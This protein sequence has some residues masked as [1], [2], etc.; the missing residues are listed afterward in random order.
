MVKNS[1]HPS[2]YFPLNIWR[3]SIRQNFPPGQ[4]FALYG[5][6][7]KIE[8]FWMMRGCAKHCC[9]IKISSLQEM[10]CHQ[11]RI[12]SGIL[13]M[14]LSQLIPDP[15]HHRDITVQRSRRRGKATQQNAERY[16]NQTVHLLQ[17]IKQGSRVNL[18]TR[19]W[20]TYVVVSFNPQSKYW[21]KT[22]IH[23]DDQG[24]RNLYGS[25]IFHIQHRFG[26]I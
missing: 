26:S 3:V 20:D 5:M 4:N 9:S 21:V 19:P 10:D 18:T 14:T 2:K 8:E 22:V 25:A 17:D 16:Y 13:Y 1:N 24:L 11:L 12:S 6:P 7:H 23:T 15:L